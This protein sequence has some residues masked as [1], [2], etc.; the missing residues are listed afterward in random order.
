VNPGSAESEFAR[1][2]YFPGC[3]LSRGDPVLYLVAPALRIHPATEIVLKYFSPRVPWTLVAV[4]ERWR[5]RVSVVWRKRS[6]IR[7]P[8]G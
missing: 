7:E 8:G 6:A 4:N 2:G 1:M 5:Q 3:R